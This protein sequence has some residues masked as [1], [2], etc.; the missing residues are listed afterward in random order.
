MCVSR[1]LHMKPVVYAAIK[2]RAVFECK[3][4]RYDQRTSM[5]VCENIYIGVVMCVVYGGEY[6][7]CVLLINV[8]GR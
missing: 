4:L 7:G 1:V 2:P 3:Y 5:R 8:C 6:R